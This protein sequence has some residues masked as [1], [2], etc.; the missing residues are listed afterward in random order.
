MKESTLW[1]T[2]LLAVHK[3]RGVKLFRNN[4]AQAWVGKGFTLKPGQT[5]RAQGGERVIMDP[6][7][8]HAGLVKG[9]GDG[10]GWRTITITPDMVGKPIAQFLS[11]ETKTRGG[12]I[13]PE[14]ATWA[15][16]VHAAGGK[17]IIAR[18]AEQAVV[19][20]QQEDIV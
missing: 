13:R 11:I 19:E 14:Q 15:K 5:Y 9:S 18:S 12:Q 16:N 3:V 4:V 20:I 7:P 1:K 6:R 2:L 8:L 10:I 17:A